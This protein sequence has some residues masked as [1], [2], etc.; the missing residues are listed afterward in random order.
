MK[1]KPTLVGV[2]AKPG[3]PRA[4]SVAL[5]LFRWLS[6]RGCDYRLDTEAAASLPPGVVPP[7]K[8]LA[9]SEMTKTC[10]VVVC[11]GGDGTLLSAVHYPVE[12]SPL[13]VGV[14]IGTLGFLNQTT[15]EELYPVL[16]QTLAG[17]VRVD[18]RY[19]LQATVVN[20]TGAAK[21][22]FYALNEVVISKEALARLIEIEFD[23]NG[24]RAASIRGDGIIIATSGGST[25][26]SLSAGGSIVHPD[27]DA[28][29][30]TPICTH[31]LTNRPLVMPGNS[32]VSLKIPGSPAAERGAVYL[33]ADGQ[34]GIELGS[35]D[36]VEVHKSRYFVDLVKSPSSH[37]Y[38]AL[39]AKLKWA[40]G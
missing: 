21:G 1:Q 13:I 10:P 29:L 6:N 36:Q 26:Y 25:A 11:L 15:V 14:N 20:K 39:S 5:E 34:Q 4:L 3:Q 35:G 17:D 19:L 16:E 33:T 31:S 38:D 2:V 12:M 22:C 23:V 9:R 24:V 32:R 37:Y 27:V 30:M 8:V 7:E 18:R 28:M 40:N